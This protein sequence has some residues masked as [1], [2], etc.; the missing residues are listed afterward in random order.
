MIG[1]SCMFYYWCCPMVLSVSR[2]REGSLLQGLQYVHN[3]L[4]L[5]CVSDGNT[6]PSKGVV[7]YGS[8]EDLLLSVMV[9]FYLNDLQQLRMLARVP[10]TSACDPS[11]ESMLAYA[12]PSYKIGIMITDLDINFLWTNPSLVLQ[13]AFY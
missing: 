1:L 5:G 3:S 9:V 13:K 10:I 4:I 6:N 11:K 12:S 7:A 2:K 8:K